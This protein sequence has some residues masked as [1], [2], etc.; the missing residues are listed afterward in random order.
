MATA[1][2][3]PFA[4]HLFTGPTDVPTST[5]PSSERFDSDLQLTVR[6]DGTPRVADAFERSKTCGGMTSATEVEMMDV[7]PGTADLW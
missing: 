1:T 5:P 2:H 7:F 4:L 3:A 6:A